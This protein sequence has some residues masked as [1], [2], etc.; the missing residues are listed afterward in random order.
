M[1]FKNILTEIKEKV[2]TIT[3]NR[4]DKLNA[5]N[6]ALGEELVSALEL[7]EENA[8]VGVIVIKG[9]GRA[10][11]A[12]YDIGPDEYGSKEAFADIAADRKQ[13]LAHQRRWWRIWECTKPVIAQVHGYCLAGG[14]ELAMMCD[15][16]ICAEDA[17][18]GY[19]PLRDMG[20]P[21]TPI[22]PWI[23]GARWAKMLYFTGD[24]IDGRTAETIGMVNFAVPGD[25]L[26]QAVNLLAE[27]I[28][29]VP[30]DLLMLHK[31]QVNR[32]FEIMGIRSAVSSGADFD[33]IGHA[34]RGAQEGFFLPAVKSG[35]KWVL[36][37]RARLFPG[38]IFDMINNLKKKL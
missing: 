12:G 16:V 26:E 10:F 1:D 6:N 21:L 28:S 14:T 29:N 18:F 23:V 32:A 13:L 22:W 27:R 11:C 8:G 19:P 38:N 20:S 2:F 5:L 33:A 24:D 34:A 15:L 9:A 35:V 25:R 31:Q 17:R 37:K 36:E 4:P 7:A 30:S 3:L